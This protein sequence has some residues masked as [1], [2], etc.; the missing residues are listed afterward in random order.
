MRIHNQ[1]WKSGGKIDIK[2]MDL[3]EL[4]AY[5]E[6][7]GQKR[8][9]AGQVFQWLHE[10]Q[11]VSFDEMTNLSKELRERLHEEC[12][13][14][15]LKIEAVQ[16]SKRDG[17]RKYLFSLADGNLVESVLMRYDYGNSVCVS[18]QIG[19]R[20]GCK[21]CAS[22]I[23]GLERSLSPAEML[24]Q[25]CKIGQDI[26]ERISHVVVMGMGEPFDNYDGVVR[27]IRL[28]TDEKGMN[29]SQRNITV[30]TCGLAPEIRRF[31][32]EGLP[33]TL[34]LSLHAAT[35]EERERLMP[36]AK[37]YKMDEVLDACAYY[38]SRTGRRVTLEY[39][40][41]AGENDGGEDARRLVMLLGKYRKCM[42]DDY[43][44]RESDQYDGTAL[45][46]D[47]ESNE[48]MAIHGTA[49]WHVNLIPI[50]PVQGRQY[51]RPTPEAVERFKSILCANGISA[52]V[53]RTLGPDIDASCGQLRR[54]YAT[55]HHDE[56]V[57]VHS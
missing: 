31:A 13:I 35:Q 39:G 3:E 50:N 44:A 46:E 22:T 23:G 51:S 24:D 21:F 29:L 19:C 36:I 26:G 41:V 6:S 45:L 14:A 56:T 53:R 42:M 7:C 47:S 5:M 57:T 10:K 37:Q 40:L 48:N 27:F 16:E 15:N 38:F 34:A 2:S 4:S 8:F 9:R 18:S 11:A 17:T 33:V 49:S 54:K 28:L 55:M 20:M 30:S 43:A 52:T 32:D 12:E 25:V 1:R